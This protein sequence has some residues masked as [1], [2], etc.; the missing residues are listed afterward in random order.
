[1]WIAVRLS[2]AECLC[3]LAEH[4]VLAGHAVCGAYGVLCSSSCAAATAAAAAA[5][6]G[7][8]GGAGFALGV[9]GVV[10]MITYRLLYFVSSL[11]T[12]L[13]LWGAAVDT[14][15]VVSH[16]VKAMYVQRLAFWILSRVSNG[17]L[18]VL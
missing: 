15:R 9:L 6:A 12:V 14:A 1:V 7:C 13:I 16:N 5:A 10:V 17:R 4:V 8:V 18:P 2:P 3:G 11:L